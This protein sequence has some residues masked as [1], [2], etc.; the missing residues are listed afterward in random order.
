MKFYPILESQNIANVNLECDLIGLRGR[1]EMKK[2]TADIDFSLWDDGHINN[3]KKVPDR[4][5]CS[6][7]KIN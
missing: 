6:K 4:G 7:Y 1:N 2:K 5:R 3:K